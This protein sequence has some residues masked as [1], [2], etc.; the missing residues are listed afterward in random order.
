MTQEEFDGWRAIQPTREILR[1]LED[2]RQNLDDLLHQLCINCTDTQTFAVQAARVQGM[3][4]GLNKLLEIEWS[5]VGGPE[6]YQEG[7]YV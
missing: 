4:V 5:D 6:D 3:I 7:K 2:E 1:Y